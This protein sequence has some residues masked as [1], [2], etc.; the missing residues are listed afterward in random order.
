MIMMTIWSYQQLASGQGSNQKDP[1]K[2]GKKKKRHVIEIVGIDPFAIFEHGMLVIAEPNALSLTTPRLGIPVTVGGEFLS[3]Q[4]NT[5]NCNYASLFLCPLYL[6]RYRYVS[7]LAHAC[8]IYR[9]VS[10][11]NSYSLT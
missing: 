1:S 7:G 2:G 9:A 3:A 8:S 10:K 5:R 4:N 6:G 11:G